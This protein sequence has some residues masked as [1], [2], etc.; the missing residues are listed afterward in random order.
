MKNKAFTLVELLVVIAII[1]TL[2]GILLPALKNART[3][4][5]EVLSLTRLRTNAQIQTQYSGDNKSNFPNPFTPAGRAGCA[6]EDSSW[7]WLRDRRCAEGWAYSNP[8]STSGT[9]SYGYHWLAHTLYGD[10]KEQSRLEII[11]APG[12]RALSQWLVNNVPAQGYVEWIFPGSYWYPPVF[13]QDT[14]RFAGAT[15]QAGGPGNRHLIRRN[16]FSD[17]VYPNQKVLLFENKDYLHPQQPMWFD[18]RA[19]VRTA[20]TDGSARSVNMSQVIGDTDPA[21]SDPTK[22]LP[23]SGT[24]NPGASEFDGY[25][26][27]GR[28]QGFSWTYGGPAYFWATRNGVRGRDFLT[29]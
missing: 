20:L 28:P 26:E 11:L 25:L 10:T 19:R 15:R 6:V 12:D 16:V 18:V 21:S 2:V 13:W 7:I 22:L 8:Y 14:R 5:R 24:W 3:A 1:A 4:A 27:Y 23:P 17:I 29:R 9:E